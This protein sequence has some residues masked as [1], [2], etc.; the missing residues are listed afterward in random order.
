MAGEAV[1]LRGLVLGAAVVAVSP[2]AEAIVDD[3]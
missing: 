1:F 3:S 2:T